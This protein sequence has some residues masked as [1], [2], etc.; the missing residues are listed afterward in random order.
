MKYGAV[1]AGPVYGFCTWDLGIGDFGV[2]H[3][4]ELASKWRRLDKSLAVLWDAGD[5]ST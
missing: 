4:L 2:Y 5:V 3:H 1:S